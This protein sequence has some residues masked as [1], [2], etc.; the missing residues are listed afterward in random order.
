MALLALVLALQSQPAAPIIIKIADPPSELNT[1]GAVLMGSL[2]LTGT[3]VLIAV[4]LAVVFGGAMFWFR[5]RG[6]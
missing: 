2:G 4:L 5:S 3:L 6:K 1:L